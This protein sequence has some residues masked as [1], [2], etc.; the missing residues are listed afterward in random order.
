VEKLIEVV[1]TAIEQP[2]LP[3]TRDYELSFGNLAA[4]RLPEVT[5]EAI[6]RA[7][8]RDAS[9]QDHVDEE[10]PDLLL[11]EL[12]KVLD[13]REM[14]AGYAFTYTNEHAD[15]ICCAINKAEA[16]NTEAQ[17]LNALK[18]AGYAAAYVS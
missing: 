2:A 15:A 13:F 4:G 6:G 5:P 12:V 8:R 17:I 7:W 10:F 3:T 16:H 18:S 9:A 14:V 11:T 1:V